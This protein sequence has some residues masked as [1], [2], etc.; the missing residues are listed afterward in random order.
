MLESLLGGLVSM[1]TQYKTTMEEDK[2][3]LKENL[4]NNVR[5]AVILR[6]SEKKILQNSIDTIKHKLK[7]VK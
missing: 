7:N 5:N 2:Q 1:Q 4:S 6:L 3:F